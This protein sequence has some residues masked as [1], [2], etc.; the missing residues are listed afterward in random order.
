MH[1]KIFIW[2]E[3]V[4][5]AFTLIKSKLTHAPLLVL[6]DFSTPFEL[7]SDDSKIAIGAVLSQGAA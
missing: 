5:A 4:V 7:N 6:P 3:D 1:G 2:T